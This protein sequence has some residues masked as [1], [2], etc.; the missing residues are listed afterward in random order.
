MDPTVPIS[1]RISSASFSFLSSDEIRAISVKAITNPILLDNTNLPTEGGL[2]DPA[3]G[4]IDNKSICKTCQ[5]SAFSC[6][7]HYGH[8]NL[9]APVFH[10]LFMTHLY[11]VLRGCCLF[12]HKFKSPEVQLVLFENC[13]KLLNYGLVQA[14][15]EI[16]KESLRG[17]KNV[18]SLLQDEAGPGG[19]G[20]ANGSATLEVED[21]DGEFDTNLQNSDEAVVEESPRDFRKRIEKRVGELVFEA[22]KSG[23]GKVDRKDDQ[24]NA[25][26]AA[27]KKL[28]N[29]FLKNVARKRCEHCH[30]V[31]P[32]LRKDGFIKIVER[33][34]SDRD[35]AMHEALGIRRPNVFAL[36]AK[37]TTAGQ[38]HPDGTSE[39][40]NAPN[41]GEARIDIDEQYEVDD[42]MSV[43]TDVPSTTKSLKEKTKDARKKSAKAS[44]ATRVMPPDECRANLRLLFEREAD[45]CGL[46]F[47]RRGPFE[48][49]YI[50]PEGYNPTNGSFGI[51]QRPGEGSGSSASGAVA[52]RNGASADSF[53]M[54]VIAVPPTRFRPASVLGDQTFENSQNELLTK[55]IN[56]SSQVR[57]LNSALQRYSSKSAVEE[58][59]PGASSQSIA[60]AEQALAQMRLQAFESLLGSMIQLQVDVNSFIDSN[61][62]PNQAAARAVPPGVKQG[63]EKKDGLFRKNMMGK[64]VNFAARSVIS[65]DVNIETNEIGV[66]PV[67]A[68]RLTYPERVT[69]HN[70]DR[71]AALV[72]N[73]PHKYPGAVAIR[74]EDGSETLLSRLSREDRTALARQL[75]TP[76]QEL[77]RSFKG[78]FS[79]VNTSTRT[80]IVNKVVLRHLQDGDILL[81]NRQP[82]L[83]KPSMMAH[84]ARVLHGERTIR[85]HYA[86]CNSYNAD[87]DGDEMNMHFPQSEAARSE[88]YNIANT[89]NQYLVPTSGSPLRGLIQDHVVAGVWMTCKDSLFDRGEYQQ[90][91][92][93]A[94]RPE[95]NYTGG[96]RVLTLPPALI[97]PRPMW[98]GKQIISTV[99]LNIQPPAP[100]EGINLQSKAKV[101]GKFWGKDH[102]MEEHVIVA[103]GELV[104]G[105]L[106][107]SQF[108]ASAY[109]LVHAVYEIY[110]AESAGK[111][112]SIFSRLFTKFLQHRAFT[113]RMD[114][115]TL[116]PTGNAMRRKILDDSQLEGRNA[117]LRTVGLS[118]E[119]AESPAMQQN[120]L[121]RLEEVLRD[122]NKL[123]ALDAES[124][125]ASNDVTSA[126]IKACIP[127]GLNRRFPHNHMQMMTVSGA[128]GSPV[129]VSSIS[130]LLGQQAL[131]GR[132]V[133]VMVSGKT[134][135]CFKPFETAAIAGGYVA[136]RFLTGIKPQE[137]YFHCMAGREGLIDT[138]VKTSRSGYLQRCLIKH[139]EGVHVAYDQTVRNSDGTVLQFHYGE[140]GLDVTKSKYLEQFD[141]TARNVP[142]FTERYQLKQLEQ[143]AERNLIETE[144]A[145]AHMKK[146]LKKPHKYPPVMSVL[147]PVK[148]LGSMSESFAKKVEA[149]IEEN[150]AQVLTLDRKT[151]KKLAKEG[152]APVEKIKRATAKTTAEMFRSVN[153]ILYRKSLVDA[154][155]A[156]GLLAAQGIGEPSTQMTLNTFHFAGHGA[157]N[158]TLGIPRLREIVMTAS[159][160]IQTPIMRLPALEGLSRDHMKTLCKDGSRLLLSQVV[161]EAVVQE[162]ISGK[163]EST[164]FSRKK[165]YVVRL[166]F[167]PAEECV[168]EYNT[169]TQRILHSLQ[170][171]FAPML[172]RELTKELKRLKRDRV[173]QQQTIGK[174]QRF[175]EVPSANE[176]EE[177]GRPADPSK[178]PQERQRSV[179]DDSD[180]DDESLVGDGDADDARRKARSANNSTYL[181]DEASESEETDS[182]ASSEAGGLVRNSDNTPATSAASIDSDSD[183]EDDELAAQVLEIENYL[184]NHAA[185]ITKFDFDKKKG[186]WAEFE[187]LLKSNQDKPLLINVVERACSASVVHEIPNISR[188][189]VPPPKPGEKEFAITAE[190]INVRGIWDFGFGKLDLDK[191]Y[192]NDIGA[193]LHNYGVEA[194]RAAIVAEMAGIFKTYGI[195]VSM[196]HLYLI[197]DYQ[198]ANGGFRPFNRSG[199]ADSSSPLLKASF[200][201]TMSFIGDAV[202]YGE[203]DSLN[204]PSGNIVVGRPIHSGTGTPIVQVPIAVA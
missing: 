197:A 80:P 22:V 38:S 118:Q 204:T 1:S 67:F 13:L 196:R 193:L 82:T 136:G 143:L 187:L 113:C 186:S 152:K 65:P 147:P 51:N 59:A 79:N 184:E 66:P 190:G 99:L 15:A 106:D 116:S 117:A 122:D 17:R 35:K 16:A 104:S 57:D 195:G 7:G 28:I 180:S 112:L 63:M 42:A 45:I 39:G 108:G 198:T 115:L 134:L 153:D 157:A 121:T 71:L 107:K 3:L 160:C 162:K 150:P 119:D 9:P 194:A 81:L 138:A 55:V 43:D 159:Q 179:N 130:C 175:N 95:G 177:D 37:Y 135:P 202:L 128:K 168:E 192:T 97:K 155:E 148:H 125:S 161:E 14:A 60:N 169:S 203:H 178:R 34:L 144:E 69:A 87:F 154:G 49:G 142:S 46:I 171:T 176:E 4:P 76:Q 124:M 88:C 120:L 164:A 127:G 74:M 62:N 10:P 102:E 19:R 101:A 47:G 132:R 33:D 139:L 140:D 2:H 40:R 173:L 6:P 149:F 54:D 8:I 21:G 111:L 174:G 12:C 11:N 85:M 185:Y 131:E 158:V 5:L 151:L 56:T 30:A 103:E 32:T 61:K 163:V 93:G 25:A 24:G 182:D 100:A 105:V 123:A 137:F 133:P 92:Y 96:G 86:N 58:T 27:R 89:D 70:V 172:E 189:L 90:L 18:V 73:G 201:M 75:M 84:K 183:D 166:N 44:S 146:A 109:G 53:F 126:V 50:P 188:L 191:M 114:D 170:A 98:T 26:Y 68:Q 91:L 31:G 78:F 145:R 110:G 94:L 129:N 156:V 52:K 83:H 64:R 23:D 72:I 36:T 181:D 77:S 200:E 20:Q 141:F 165:S 48:L 29:E 41:D 167:Y 199:I